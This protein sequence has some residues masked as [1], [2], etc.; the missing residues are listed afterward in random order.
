MKEIDELLQ[1]MQ[2][3]RDPENGC[4]WDQK[5]TI[6]SIMPFT[7]EEVYE[8][9]D[10]I[11]RGDMDGLRDELGDLLFHIIFYAQLASEQEVFNFR[12]LVAAINMKLRNRHPHVFAEDS[13]NSLA[14]QTHTWEK[15]KH[16][17]RKMRN[18]NASLLD[19]INQAQPAMS[20][21]VA[22]QKRAATVG[23]DWPGPLPVLEKLEEEIRELRLAIESA[24][25][26]N[27]VMA[28]IGDVIF[29][30][31]NLARHM[32][33]NPEV[34]VR[35]TNRKFEQRFRYLE[36]NLAASNKELTEAT[37]AEM[38]SLWQEAKLHET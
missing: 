3:L 34:A 25:S 32:D 33:I 27:A 36:Q 38:E 7:L 26:R 21:A 23:F 37:L 35:Q 31:A 28:E 11:E 4:P 10:A 22:L 2:T 29:S 12:E 13:V 14:E 1:I 18:Q 5:Q 15:I 16:Q 20:R 19:A 9:A 30:C 24:Q 6:S 17:E 8:I